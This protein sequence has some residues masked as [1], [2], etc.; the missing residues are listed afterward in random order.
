MRI[1]EKYCG[2][3][4]MTPHHGRKGPKRVVLPDG[5]PILMGDERYLAPEILFFPKDY[6]ISQLGVVDIIY[7]AYN[8]VEN[9]ER[10]LLSQVILSGGGALFDSFALRIREEHKKHLAHTKIKV[11]IYIYWL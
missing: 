3:R 1:K 8:L 2:F 4:S 5:T 10:G 6:G 9:S 7:S 11:Y